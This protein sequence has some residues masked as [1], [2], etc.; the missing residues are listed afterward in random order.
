VKTEAIKKANSSM[1]EARAAVKRV[2]ETIEHGKK[3]EV[4]AENPSIN[5]ADKVR[6]YLFLNYPQTIV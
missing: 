5:A 2:L 3:N 6:N 1:D 4:T